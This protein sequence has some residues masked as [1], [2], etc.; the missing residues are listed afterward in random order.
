MRLNSLYEGASTP[1]GH[2]GSTLYRLME[3]PTPLKEENMISLI[4]FQ[5]ILN[6]ILELFG[7]RGSMTLVVAHN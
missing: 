1:L 6:G 7:G 3:M 4:L 2:Q 5:N